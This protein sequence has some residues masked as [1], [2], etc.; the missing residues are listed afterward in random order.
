MGGSIEKWA[1][2]ATAH[3]AAIIGETTPSAKAQRKEF[4]KAKQRLRTGTDKDGNFAYGISQAQQGQ[5]SARARQAVAGEAAGMQAELARQQAAGQMSGGQGTEAN[6]AISG[7]ALAAV[8]Q[9]ASAEQVASNQIAQQQYMRD[10]GI[11]DAQAA[12][13]RQFNDKQGNISMQ[14]TGAGQGATGNIDYGAESDAAKKRRDNARQAPQAPGGTDQGV[15][16]YGS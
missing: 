8:A 1:G 6:R 15:L 16:E 3:G 2:G 13:G 14:T 4:K 5:D 12:R 11:I 10:V 9:A 7:Q